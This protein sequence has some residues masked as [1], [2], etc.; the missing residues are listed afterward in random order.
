MKYLPLIL[1]YLPVLAAQFL[2]AAVISCVT[3]HLLRRRFGWVKPFLITAAVL[4]FCMVVNLVHPVLVC[5][6]ESEPYLTDELRAG[7][8]EFFTGAEDFPLFPLYLEVTDARD[9]YVEVKKHWMYGGTTRFEV[10]IDETGN[11]VPDLLG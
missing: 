1:F 3:G 9:G 8:R 5:P 7:I 2:P 11:A 6:A 10:S 4:V